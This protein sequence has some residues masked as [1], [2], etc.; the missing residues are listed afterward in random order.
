MPIFPSLSQRLFHD[1]K[2]Q[3]SSGGTSLR[4]TTDVLGSLIS[5][6]LSPHYWEDRGKYCPSYQ[7]PA[8][9]PEMSFDCN[10]AGNTWSSL[11][12]WLPEGDG[13]CSEGTTLSYSLV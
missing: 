2:P 8:Q 1:H 4:A 13:L 5:F 3:N 11:G 7:L 12:A 10:S 9:S 6:R